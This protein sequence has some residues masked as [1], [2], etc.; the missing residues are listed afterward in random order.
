VESTGQ[1]TWQG[2]EL[3]AAKLW[4]FLYACV[5][6]PGKLVNHEVTNSAEK[7]KLLR[8]IKCETTFAGEYQTSASEWGMVIHYFC[9]Y[10][11]C[12]IPD[13][14]YEAARMK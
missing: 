6:F 13:E 8:I 2:G 7:I 14:N 4:L 1:G 5:C 9:Q 11:T 10:N 12:E 3:S